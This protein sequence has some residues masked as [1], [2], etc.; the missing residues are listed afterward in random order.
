MTLV[1]AVEIVMVSRQRQFTIH[2][3]MW[4]MKSIRCEE[5]DEI[6]TY[7]FAKPAVVHR[8]FH[9]LIA[10]FHYHYR[11]KFVKNGTRPVCK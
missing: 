1:G 10:M 9:N 6:L 2:Y 7:N 5:C 11:L 8:N 3:F 4:N